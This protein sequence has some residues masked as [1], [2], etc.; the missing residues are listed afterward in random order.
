MDPVFLQSP[1]SHTWDPLVMPSCSLGTSSMFL[2]LSRPLSKLSSESPLHFLCIV[3]A[4]S[5]VRGVLGDTWHDSP[6][7]WE[8][9]EGGRGTLEGSTMR[10]TRHKHSWIRISV[11]LISTSETLVYKKKVKIWIWIWNVT[12]RP[13]WWG[14]IPSHR[15]VLGGD[16]P[17]REM[18]RNERLWG[19]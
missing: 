2:N 18:P 4:S 9:V 7:P 11:F 1:C 15:D 10:S 17:F 14:F 19:H 13:T 6:D 3:G 16:R 8:S 5:R 12:Q